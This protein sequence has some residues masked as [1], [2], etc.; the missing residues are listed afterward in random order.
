MSTTGRPSPR[1][2]PTP[3]RRG[4]PAGGRVRA[5][6][7]SRPAGG[8]SSA[9]GPARHEAVGVL[10]ADTVPARRRDRAFSWRYVAAGRPCARS[11]LSASPRRRCRL[12]LA[13][14]LPEPFAVVRP[15]AAAL[16]IGARH[17]SLGSSATSS[18][19][20]RSATGRPA[21]RL[22]I[23][24]RSPQRSASAASGGE[25][26]AGDRPAAIPGRGRVHGAQVAVALRR[27]DESSG[28]VEGATNR[29]RRP[30]VV[31][32]RG[33]QRLARV[34]VV[35]ERDVNRGLA[36]EPHRARARSADADVLLP[37]S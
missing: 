35:D 36:P 31:N 13:R 15:P 30:G 9:S 22:P 1:G 21:R 12:Q 17:P 20:G 18:V 14:A 32:P 16:D 4:R 2:T 26:A 37:W 33:A 28:H 19:A 25:E 29:S 10:E 7:E 23:G 27:P 11:V 34:P 24:S 6:L 8:P 3:Y 5:T